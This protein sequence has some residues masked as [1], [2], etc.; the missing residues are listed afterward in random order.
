VFHRNRDQIR[1]KERV[2]DLLVVQVETNPRVEV[3][4][5]DRH[6]AG[7]ERKRKRGGDAALECPRDKARPAILRH[8]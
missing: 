4:C 8:V 2:V 7:D 3:E 1:E 6:A 5:S